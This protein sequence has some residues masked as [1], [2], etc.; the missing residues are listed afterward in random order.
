MSM[1]PAKKTARWRVWKSSREARPSP[2]TEFGAALQAEIWH[3]RYPPVSVAQALG[4]ACG[5]PVS[6]ADMRVF[7]GLEILLR[8]RGWRFIGECSGPQQLTFS[9]PP[10]EAGVDYRR[11][12]LEP[13]TTVVVVVDRSGPTDTAS[14]C[15]VEILLVGAPHGHAHL[16]NLA[17]LTTHLAVIE[18]H[19]STDP[20][21]LPFLPI[22]RAH[23]G[24]RVDRTAPALHSDIH[25]ADT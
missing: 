7:A 20:T 12:G 19:R 15:Q 16:T 11:L 3:R 25:S 17:V 23:P 24:Q 13:V 5:H 2:P 6:G 22:G 4:T 1:S 8:A 10:S 18:S 21:P 14:G 9:Y